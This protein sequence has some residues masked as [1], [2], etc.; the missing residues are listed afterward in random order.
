MPSEGLQHWLWFTLE[1]V[2]GDQA[3][4]FASYHVVCCSKSE[5]CL[6]QFVFFIAFAAHLQLFGNALL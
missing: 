3:C 1:A 6:K 2:E 4:S 5:C